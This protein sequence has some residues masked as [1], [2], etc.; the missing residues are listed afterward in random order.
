MPISLLLHSFLSVPWLDILDQV[1]YGVHDRLQITLCGLY[2]T[3]PGTSPKRMNTINPNIDPLKY[4]CYMVAEERKHCTC[5]NITIIRQFVPHWADKYFRHSSPIIYR[6]QNTCR[7]AAFCRAAAVTCREAVKMCGRC[8]ARL[9]AMPWL[10]KY[11]EMGGKVH[12][13]LT[14]NHNIYFH[15]YMHDASVPPKFACKS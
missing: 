6:A 9:A 12:V 10:S 1:E 2:F 7:H 15:F 3:S 8:A 4:F 13:K 14:T 11:F 5:R